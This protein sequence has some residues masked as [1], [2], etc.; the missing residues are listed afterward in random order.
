M[1]GANFDIRKHL[2]EYDDVLN[3][4]RQR[5]Y[6]QRD[7]IFE[8]EDLVEDVN[9]LLSQE[10]ERRVKEAHESEEYW[11]LLAWLEQVQPPFSTPEG[12]F[13]PFTYKL[14]LD[15]LSGSTAD[16]PTALHDLATRAIQA[17]QEHFLNTVLEM[18]DRAGTDLK[19]QTEERL[20]SLDTAL[21]GLA[22]NIETEER[23]PNVIL[24]EFS[25]LVRVPFKLDS[26][27]LTQL[28]NDPK[29]LTDDLH[30]QVEAY[31]TSTSILRLANTIEFRLGEPLGLD[32]AE[33]QELDWDDVA[34][35]V[36]AHVRQALAARQEKLLGKD[37]QI[38]RDLALTL[39]R[40]TE[41]DDQARLRLLGLMAQGTS[42][43]FD[44]R[45][46]R[47][48][49]QVFTR[50]HYVYLVG[51]ILRN[52]DSEGLEEEVLEHLQDAQAAQRR[53]WGESERVR[54]G[55]PST[56]PQIAANTEGEDGKEE[57][58]PVDELGHNIQTQ[59]Y[60]QVL[61]GAITELWVD[62][63]TRVEAL[64]ISVGLEAYAQSDP[65]VKYKSQASEMFQNL[66]ADIRSAVIG[67][68]FLYQPRAAAVQAETSAGS[69]SR[70]DQ[71]EAI[72]IWPDPGSG[73]KPG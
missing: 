20:D 8:K 41:H 28:V 26:T 45:T 71:V 23:R 17:D 2:L 59:I 62:Y 4:Q 12:I 46:H 21:D 33:L 70:P 65:L 13:P 55:I 54:L 32:A 63:L 16:L 56:S 10:V 43:S 25:G 15:E 69:S 24:E 18:V 38:T 47:Q 11:R 52:S 9:E 5:I 27:Q 22:D 60:R 64:R 44:A 1:E 36:E 57:Q 48:V 73:A 3:A 72:R 37:G 6:S 35:E 29:D 42:T 51:E 31:V 61:L 53:A 68:I 50:L 19:T 49:R 66:L 30:A 14:L 34:S 39:E 58:D 40:M 7:R 67:R